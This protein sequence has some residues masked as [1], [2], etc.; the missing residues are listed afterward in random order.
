MTSLINNTMQFNTPPLPDRDIEELFNLQGTL[1]A[2]EAVPI[3]DNIIQKTSN[4]LESVHLTLFSLEQSLEEGTEEELAVLESKIEEMAPTVH[5]LS[6]ASEILI[7]T[8]AEESQIRF[9]VTKIQS[10][11]SSLHHFMV[12]VKQQQI[13]SREQREIASKIETLLIQMD[14]ISLMMF[15]FQEKKY[16]T[17]MSPSI[18]ERDDTFSIH[19]DT[20]SLANLAGRDDSSV[21]EIDQVFDA[22]LKETQTV[23]TRMSQLQPQELVKKRFDKFQAKWE[24]LQIERDEFKLEYKE[25][26]WSTVFRRV[27][28]QVDVMI[29]GLDRSLVQC[30][31]FVQQ[32]KAWYQQNKQFMRSYQLP[33]LPIDTDR[34][35]S[36]E[37][38]FEAKYKYYTPSIDRMLT[39]LGNGIMSRGSR[40]FIIQQ[41]HESMIQRW[42]RLKDAIQDLRL[43]DLVDVEKIISLCQPYSWK[44]TRYR[45]PEPTLDTR[46]RTAATSLHPPPSSLRGSISD[47]SSSSLQSL[48]KTRTPRPTRNESAQC[49]REDFYEEDEKKYGLDFMKHQTRVRRTS[50]HLISR[51]STTQEIRPRSKTPNRRAPSAQPVLG[52]RSKSSMGDL[53]TDRMLSPRPVTP[54]FIP[55]PRTPKDMSRAT[56]PTIPPPVPSLPRYASESTLRKKQSMPILRHK[57]SIMEISV[58]ETRSYRSNPKDPLDVEVAHIVNASPI[59]IQCQRA[60]HGK[61]YFGNEFSLSST[62]GKKLYTCKL[63]TYTARKNGQAKNNK[64]LIRV[65]GGWQDLEFFLLE[66]SSLMASDVVVRTYTAS[67]SADT[68]SRSRAWN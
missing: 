50:T 42:Y 26:R 23:F 60:D 3:F 18:S 15:D 40:D 34:F 37:K 27:S 8:G 58:N 35:K 6:E 22:I 66:H 20:S 47:S 56:S 51:P 1:G 28:D 12:S 41:R 45:T 19:S 31:T 33:P 55:R 49:K 43:Q 39:I 36:A 29:D 53:R 21:T 63:M 2:E 13:D 38:S 24:Q 4:W 68:S 57:P 14:D 17:V 59:A 7:D 25:D 61:Y 54:S 65:G 10:E 48:R 62:G 5:H 64:V 11:W 67:T 30:Q 46:P 52:F 16:T 32:I 9:R 44:E